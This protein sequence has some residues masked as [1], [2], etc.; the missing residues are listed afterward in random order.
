MDDKKCGNCGWYMTGD[1]WCHNPECVDDGF[2]EHMP[3]PD[4]VYME[5]EPFVSQDKC[6][7]CGV[8][9]AVHNTTRGQACPKCAGVFGL[10]LIPDDADKVDS[11]EVEDGFHAAVQVAGYSGLYARYIEQHEAYASFV[12]YLQ[13]NPDE[14]RVLS[15]MVQDSAQLHESWKR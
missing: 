14:L 5:I 10:E 2:N 3:L 12:D 7:V 9:D 15:E 6:V 13:K 11:L 1:W 8:Y 4:E